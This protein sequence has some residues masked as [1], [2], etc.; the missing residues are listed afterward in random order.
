MTNTCFFVLYKFIETNYNKSIDREHNQEYEKYK[1]R[2]LSNPS[3]VE[4][5]YF[6]S[7]KNKF[8]ISN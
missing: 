2:I 1:N 5:Q 4:L 6:E 7:I 3:E 8:Q